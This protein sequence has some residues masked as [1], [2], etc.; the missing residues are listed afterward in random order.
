MERHRFLLRIFAALSCAATLAF[1]GGVL[2]AA[3]PAVQ[4]VDFRSQVVF[5]SKRPPGYAAW[6]SFFPGEHGQWYIGCEEVSRPKQPLPQTSRL[7]W[8]GMGLPVGYDKSQYLMEAVLLESTDDLKT[9][10]VISREAYRHQ[11]SVHQFGSAR[12]KDGRF[13]RFNWACYSLDPTV[14]TNEILRVSSDNGK[15]WKRV[16]PFLTDRFA[17]YP[18]RLR[19]LR[20][21]TLVLCLPIAPRWGKDADRP[22]RTAM[23]LDA[24][25]EMKMTLFFS[26]DQGRSW[27]GPLPIFDGVIVSET[28]FVE[29][30]DGNLLF[31]NNRIF[32]KPGRQFV[33]RDGNRFIPGPLENVRSGAVPETVCLTKAGILVGTHRPGSYAWSDDLGQTWN[34]LSGIASRGPEVYQP[35]IYALPDGRIA[36]AG[37]YGSDDPIGT[38]RRHQNYINLHTFR[39]KVNRRT[40]NTKIRVQRDYDKSQRRW[41]NRFTVSLTADGKPLPDKELE[42]WYV[43]RYK[44]GYDSWNASPLS[45]RMKAGGT[46]IKPKTDAEGKARVKLPARFDKITNPH[47]SYQLVVRFNMHRSD[48]NYKPYQTP[49]F[50]FYAFAPMP[51]KLKPLK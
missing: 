40:K 45:K 3:E 7:A 36:C 14:K 39:L 18:H 20:D 32:A 46:T 6:V 22:V 8:Y 24:N 31:F 25:N 28:D 27:Q 50:E 38:G 26:F 43:E 37:H 42:F 44:P 47:L 19:T 35:S 16:P 12:T 5:R 33:Y 17:Y 10:K 23:R 21:G 30:P 15:T 1:G 49:Q 13:L 4:A 2:T 9:W 41:L 48:P 29:L 11:H 34:G 51:P